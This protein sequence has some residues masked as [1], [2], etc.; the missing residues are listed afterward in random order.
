[1]E[2][3]T[4]SGSA[5]NAMGTVEVLAYATAVYFEQVDSSPL[6]PIESDEIPP[7]PSS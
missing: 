1:M 2:T 7:S 4:I 3:S 5:E 6:A